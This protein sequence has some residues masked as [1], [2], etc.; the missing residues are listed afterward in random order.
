MQQKY[1]NKN[2]IIPMDYIS[3]STS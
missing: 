1:E 3:K 2:K